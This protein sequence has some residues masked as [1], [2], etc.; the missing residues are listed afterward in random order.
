MS[1]RFRLYAIADRGVFASDQAW[2]QAVE[3]AA[4]QLQRGE[5]LQL[6]VKSVAPPERRKLLAAARNTTRCAVA[7]VFVNGTTAEAAA[8]GFTGV[9][10]PEGAIPARPEDGHLVRGASV[11]SLAALQRAEA[12]GADFA[13]AGPVFDPFSKPGTGIGLEAFARIARSSAIPVLAVG[14]IT[15]ERVAA[16]LEAGAAGVAVVS[17]LFRTAALAD[18]LASYRA[19]L[20]QLPLQAETGARSCKPH[21]VVC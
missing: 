2:L 21:I 11:H 17:S 5:A 10:W 15:P 8:L 7:P 19:V 20:S 18:A 1:V 14:G 4:R 13:V 12:A 6:R 16:C 9:H 3:E